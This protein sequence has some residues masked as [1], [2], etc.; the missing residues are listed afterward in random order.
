MGCK[1]KS[2]FFIFFFTIKKTLLFA[3]CCYMNTITISFGAGREVTALF[4]CC[5]DWMHVLPIKKNNCYICQL[6]R[7][8]YLC[9]AIKLLI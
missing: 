5:H 3:M 9:S 4:L 1:V 8:I 7:I 6:K 2:K